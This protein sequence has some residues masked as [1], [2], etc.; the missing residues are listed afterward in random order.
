MKK[1]LA[2]IAIGFMCMALNGCNRKAQ[3]SRDEE[4]QSETIQVA[5]TIKNIEIIEKNGLI[6]YYPKYSY[7]DLVCEKMPT[8]NDTNILMCCEAAFTGK[9]LDKFDHL[10]IAGNHVSSGKLYHGYSCDANTGCFTFYGDDKT[11]TFAVGDYN[12]Y[13]EDASKR[14]GMAFGQS[15]LILDGIKQPKDIQKATTAHHYRVLAE[16]DDKLCIID[17]KE[18]VPFGDFAKMLLKTGVKNALYLDM[19]KGWNYSYYRDNNGNIKYIHDVQI[20]Y[21]TNWITFYK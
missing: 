17:S 10:N 9:E 20:K 14:N 16:L 7:I 1:N 18:I 6:I 12:N 5:D 15:M 21:T 11:W 19:G 2:I 13:V 4:P 3:E 8:P